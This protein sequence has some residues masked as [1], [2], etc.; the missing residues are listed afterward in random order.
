MN[1]VCLTDGALFVKGSTFCSAAPTV[2]KSTLR[3]MLS[4]H[5]PQKSP[6][7]SCHFEPVK[8]MRNRLQAERTPAKLQLLKQQ[9]CRRAPRQEQFGDGTKA[10]GARQTGKWGQILYF[11]YHFLKYLPEERTYCTFRHSWCNVNRFP[12][13]QCLLFF[14]WLGRTL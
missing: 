4:S 5:D 8:G 12:N 13:L 6:K 10:G 14:R 2:L 11:K 1:F 3:T 9:R 7:H